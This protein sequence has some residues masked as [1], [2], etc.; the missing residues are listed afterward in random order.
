MSKREEPCPSGEIIVYQAEDGG[1]RIRVVLE[2]ESVWL[3]QGLLAELYQTTPQNI[4]LHIKAIY[5]GGEL[6]EEATCKEY[7]QV[8]TEGSRK[9]ERKLKHYNLDV[10]LAVGYRVRSP[11]KVAGW[12]SGMWVRQRTTSTRERSIRSTASP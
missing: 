7:L 8:R 9:V 4:T 2:G 3:T 6:V 12:S 1:S 5:G 10:V 11:R